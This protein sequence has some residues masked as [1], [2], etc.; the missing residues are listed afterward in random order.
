MDIKEIVNFQTIVENSDICIIPIYSR[1]RFCSEYIRSLVKEI[2][3]RNRDYDPNIDYACIKVLNAIF[4]CLSV[5]DTSA[6][7]VWKRDKW[8]IFI[9]PD[10]MNIHSDNVLSLS[11]NKVTL[12]YAAESDN[13]IVQKFSTIIDLKAPMNEYPD[14]WSGFVSVWGPYMPFLTIV[15]E[16][17]HLDIHYID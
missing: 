16:E 8:F 6:L 5:R 15:P 13:H 1:R 3:K 14:E 10:L 4:N 2:Y 12:K 17:W 11:N 7:S 9:R